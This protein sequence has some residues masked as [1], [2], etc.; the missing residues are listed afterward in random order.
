M[1]KMFLIACALSLSLV[2][3]PAISFGQDATKTTTPSVQ[4][5]NSTQKTAK[6]KHNGKHHKKHAKK[7]NDEHT[8]A[9]GTVSSPAAK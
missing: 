8:N 3:V 7:S 9:S 1:K 5:D 4:N 6:K 2:F